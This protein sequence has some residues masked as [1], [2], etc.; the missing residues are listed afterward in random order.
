MQQ[1][2]KLLYIVERNCKIIAAKP[3]PQP[4]H[5]P[6]QSSQPALPSNPDT[7]VASRGPLLRSRG[8]PPPFPSRYSPRGSRVGP[9][10]SQKQ[11]S[12]G[13]IALQQVS[14]LTHSLP[15]CCFSENYLLLACLCLTDTCYLLDR[16]P[17]SCCCDATPCQGDL[18][19]F[20][21]AGCALTTTVCSWCGVFGLN[22]EISCVNA[23]SKMPTCLWC[24]ARPRQREWMLDLCN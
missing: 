7:S 24:S 20:V 16:S 12:K 18:S 8:F 5:A 9:E 13:A 1:L 19:R 3:K 4:F 10:G 2:G 22:I 17:V 23:S 11:P 6:S 14:T 15:S 21:T